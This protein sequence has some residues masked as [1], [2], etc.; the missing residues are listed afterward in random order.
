MTRNT[1]AMRQKKETIKMREKSKW[2]CPTVPTS[3]KW[4]KHAIIII[5]VFGRVKTINSI[6]NWNI[7]TT[8][9]RGAF[10]F[11]DIVVVCCRCH[12]VTMCAVCTSTCAFTIMTMRVWRQMKNTK[13]KTIN[14]TPNNEYLIFAQRWISS[15]MRW[16]DH[17][18][19]HHR[20]W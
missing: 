9:V 7:T 4:M 5:S 16:H 13:K 18:C 1:E 10:S 17:M 20:H 8:V 3:N 2:V 11:S 19:S 15:Y 12:S 14:R 6:Y